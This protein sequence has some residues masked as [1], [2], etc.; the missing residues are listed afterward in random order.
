VFEPETV[1][2]LEGGCALI[3]GTAA[4]GVPRATRGWGLDVLDGGAVRVLLS[5]DDA[6]P[7][8]HLRAGMPIAITG[9]DVRTLR[10][11]QVKGRVLTT[12]PGTTADAERA[13]R[14]H[15]AFFGDIV[16]TDGTPRALLERMMPSGYLSCA[17]AVDELYDQTP[18]PGAG[19]ALRGA[20]EGPAPA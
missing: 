5:R 6:P 19:A 3:V 20:S 17:V 10:S 4:G 1:R 18:G 7:A 15:E 13:R 9:A 8:D 11:A 16:H 2:F 12:E 14:Y